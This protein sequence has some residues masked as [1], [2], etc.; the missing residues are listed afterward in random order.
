MKFTHTIDAFLAI[1]GG[2]LLAFMVRYNSLLAHHSTPVFASGV[3]HG[4]GALAAGLIV[5]LITLKKTQIPAQTVNSKIPLWAHLGGLSGGFTIVLTALTVNSRLVL[6]GTIALMILGQLVFG[7]MAD[8]FG[9][10]GAPKRRFVA[11]DALM[12]IC[13]FAGSCLI[14]FS[15][16]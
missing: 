10:F 4:V 2:L 9:F 14:I 16:A 15:K 6:T 13:V 12:L 1:L 8:L 11:K 5:T 7:L 3:A